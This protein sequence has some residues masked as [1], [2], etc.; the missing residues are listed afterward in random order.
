MSLRR[1]VAVVP[2]LVV[3]LSVVLA[4]QA[5]APNVTGSWKG[6]F[7]VTIDDQPS[8]ES[9]ALVIIKQNGAE[10]TGTAGPDADQQYGITKGKVTTEKDVT[11]VSFELTTDGPLVVFELK[12]V[13]GHLKGTARAEFEG[14]KMKAEVDL[15]RAK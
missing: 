7:I 3:L 2:A 11:T 14:R 9:T 12:L 15:E 5:P 13:E 8:N 6:K 10:L 4:A 1:S